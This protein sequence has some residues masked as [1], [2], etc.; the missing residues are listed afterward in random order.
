MDFMSG[1]IAGGNKFKTFNVIDIFTR[2]VL[3]IH[4]AASIPSSIVA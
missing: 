4:V 3:A 1:E 2:E